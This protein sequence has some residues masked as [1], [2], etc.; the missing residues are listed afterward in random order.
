MEDP[1]KEATKLLNAGRYKDAI[2]MAKAAIK[3]DPD[4]AQAYMYLAEAYRALGKMKDMQATYDEC[5]QRPAK[6]AAI[7]CP[8][9]H[10]K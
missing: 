4:N 10:K 6:G 3:A 5:I 9:G 8:Y 1:F 2:P 7:H